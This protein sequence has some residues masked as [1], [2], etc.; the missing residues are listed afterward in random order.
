[1]GVRASPCKC[2]WQHH[3]G[4]KEGRTD[5]AACAI[6]KDDEHYN[7]PP[8]LRVVFQERLEGNQL[9]GEAWRE[10]GREGGREVGEDSK[11]ICFE[12]RPERREG[13]EGT[14]SLPS[15]FQM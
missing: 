14:D 15:P 2:R 3:E 6:A 1:M 13:G 9:L 7:L 4:G 10:G 12:G 11:A 8:P 5:E